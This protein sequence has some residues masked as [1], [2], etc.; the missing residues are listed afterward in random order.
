[1]MT[2]ERQGDA[3]WQALARLP[4]GA[5]VVV[6]H[7]SLPA[8]ERARLIRAVAL[9]GRRKSLVVVA[10][11]SADRWYLAGHHGAS[12]HKRRGLKTVSAHNRREIVA[13]EK[14]GADLVFLSPVFPTRSHPGARGLGRVR[15][16]LLAQS[17]RLPVIALGGMTAMRAEALGRAACGWAGIDAWD[18]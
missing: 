16:S 12:A 14:A 6:R 5:G 17:T 10:A 1:M 18:C 15:F 13:A 7:Y 2:D 9:A 4:R 3:F 11:D 8:G